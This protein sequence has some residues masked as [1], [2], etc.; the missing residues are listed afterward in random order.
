MQEIVQKAKNI[1]R[2]LWWS[3]VISGAIGIVFGLASLLWP[4][5]ILNF[6]VYAFAAFALVIS[7]IALAQSI[8]N[9]KL[10]PLWWLSSLLSLCGICLGIYIFFN[11]DNMHSFLG[12]LLAVFIFVQALLDLIMASYAEA[13]ND[14]TITVFLGIVGL[15]AGF[16]VLLNP[17]LAAAATVW[18]IGAYI[19]VHGIMIEIYAFRIKDNMRM[20]FPNMGRKNGTIVIEAE[21]K[22]KAKKPRT[23]KAHKSTKSDTE[24]R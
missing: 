23:R 5:V 14:K 8:T 16:I 6:F 1:A 3:V 10:D 13:S 15:I 21:V 22:P 19:L 2:S 12:I 7:T 9:L 18:I 17:G 11:P 24:A 4:V 20:L